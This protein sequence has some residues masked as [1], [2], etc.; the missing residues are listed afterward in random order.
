MYWTNVVGTSG[1]VSVE[2][3][4]CGQP[5]HL[6]TD[7]ERSSLAAAAGRDHGPGPRSGHSRS[8]SPVLY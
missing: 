6:C 4:Y 1:Q 8:S 3:C 2:L 7:L 5:G